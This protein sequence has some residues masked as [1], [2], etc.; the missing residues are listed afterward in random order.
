MSS[1]ANS[2]RGS[3]TIQDGR[4]ESLR[5]RWAAHRANTA[6]SVERKEVSPSMDKETPPAS[7]EPVLNVQARIHAGSA[8]LKQTWKRFRNIEKRTRG[9]NTANA[10]EVVAALDAARDVLNKC[11]VAMQQAGVVSEKLLLSAATKVNAVTTAMRMAGTQ[12]VPQE[13]MVSPSSTSPSSPVDEGMS[14]SADEGAS[15]LEGQG[16]HKRTVQLPLWALDVV[17]MLE[18]SKAMATAVSQA[19]PELCT[20]TYFSMHLRDL[21]RGQQSR[22]TEEIYRFVDGE[23]GDREEQSDAYQHRSQERP[24]SERRP[25]YTSPSSLDQSISE[26][27]RSPTPMSLEA[28]KFKQTLCQQKADDKAHAW[29]NG[30]FNGTPK[31]APLGTSRGTGSG[32]KGEVGSGKKSG[33]KTKEIGLRDSPKAATASQSPSLMKP[34]SPAYGALLKNR[35]SPT[36]KEYYHAQIMKEKLRKTA[37]ADAEWCDK[38]SPHGNS[39]HNWI[40]SLSKRTSGHSHRF[41]IKKSHAEHEAKRL[42]RKQ[43]NHGVGAH[44]HIHVPDTRDAAHV[45]QHH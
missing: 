13:K 39:V 7:E 20:P 30:K 19:L 29:S 3:V 32:K 23:Q 9:N 6:A 44:Q 42:A 37:K 26:R 8:V 5:Q 41:V 38:H 34:R 40:E 18:H 10:V 31:H 33:G 43:N 11:D 21:S 28:E 1:F 17:I 24:V 45:L 35:K 25:V 12:P 4:G 15:T 36:K 27:S 16:H 2:R 22:I 14:T